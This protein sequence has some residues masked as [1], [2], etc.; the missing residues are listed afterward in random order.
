MEVNKIYNMD[1]ISGMLEM[2][3]ESV[4]LI[5]TDP[6]YNTGM[7]GKTS[8]RFGNK[9]AKGNWLGGFFNDNYTDE[10]YEGLVRNVCAQLYRV[11]KND[12]A[13]YI[14]INWKKLGLWLHTLESVGFSIKNV[15]VWDKVVH[16]LN[17]QNYAYTHEFIIFFVKGRFFPSNK[18]YNC[19]KQG[20]YKDVWAIR[21]DLGNDD[22]KFEHETVKQ[23]NVIK[24]P[25]IHASEEGDLVLDPFMGSGTT[26]V[27][28]KSLRRNFIGFELEER[29]CQLAQR[30]LNQ[31]TLEGTYF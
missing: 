7:D 9:D 11:L 29:Y 27:A 26:A 20:L 6:P 22:A 16:G 23:I 15:I 5:V 2:D 25:I 8:G 10:E 14:F 30:R 28:S 3:D 24:T 18:S 17:Y 13:G 1:C 4:D 19:K 21:R 12:K 31:N